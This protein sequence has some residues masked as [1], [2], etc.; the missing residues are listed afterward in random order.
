MY[1]CFKS[2]ENE[3]K[4]CKQYCKEVVMIAVLESLD[5]YCIFIATHF[6]VL[7]PPV[8]AVHL[9]NHTDYYE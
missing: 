4:N 8:K 3:V 9:G 7:L 5:L 1:G 6:I 2:S